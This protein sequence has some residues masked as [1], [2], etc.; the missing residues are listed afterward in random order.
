MFDLWPLG[1]VIPRAALRQE[2]NSEGKHLLANMTSEPWREG[3]GSWAELG[4]KPG[5]HR[6][7]LRRVSGGGD[8]TR[9]MGGPGAAGPE[10]DS[11]SIILE[12]SGTH[13]RLSTEGGKDGHRLSSYKRWEGSPRGRHAQTPYSGEVTPK[14]SAHIAQKLGY[15]ERTPTRN[16]TCPSP[17]QW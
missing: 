3:G 5:R 4:P 6:C 1:P 11:S 12:S 9:K 14:S 17:S 16:G 8:V 10:G 7:F 13:R 15:R 2:G